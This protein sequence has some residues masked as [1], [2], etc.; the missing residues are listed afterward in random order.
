MKI[1]VIGY[2]GEKKIGS[3][4]ETDDRLEA[5]KMFI[6]MLQEKDKKVHLDKI[7]IDTDVE[8]I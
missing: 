7:E 6:E 1:R 8:Y 3:I 5:I 2:Y 4:I